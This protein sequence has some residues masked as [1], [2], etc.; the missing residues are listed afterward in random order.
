MRTQGLSRTIMKT[1]LIYGAVRGPGPPNCVTTR[2]RELQILSKILM[3]RSLS[4]P[5]KSITICF[6]NIYN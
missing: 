3:R 5:I 4:P 2:A 1:P 6:I